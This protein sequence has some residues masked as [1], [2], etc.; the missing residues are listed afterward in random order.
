MSTYLVA[1]AVSDYN[2]TMKR[3]KHRIITKHE[4]I[5]RGKV[6]YI[7]SISENLMSILENFTAI[8]YSLDKLDEFTV[9][10]EYFIPGGMENWGLI[11]IR[12]ILQLND[13]IT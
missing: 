3:G 10:S 2:F 5:D 13:L 4:G 1:F 11:T 7:L 6:D 9:P 12:Y 8:N